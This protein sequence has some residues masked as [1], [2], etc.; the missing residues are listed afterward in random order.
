MYCS[1]SNLI[2]ASRRGSRRTRRNIALLRRVLVSPLQYRC[3]ASRYG[4]FRRDRAHSFSSVSDARVFQ[5]DVDHGLALALAF[6]ALWKPMG[7]TA[8]R[9]PAIAGPLSP[10]ETVFFLVKP[11]A[12]PRGI[13]R[14]RV[15]RKNIGYRSGCRRTRRKVLTVPTFLRSAHVFR[16]HTQVFVRDVVTFRV[17]ASKVSVGYASKEGPPAAP[18]ISSRLRVLF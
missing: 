4:L 2:R 14:L 16:D 8:A 10:R 15:L 12:R 18:F 13:R 5:V 6:V 1:S 7:R 9:M 17:G 11:R 3:H